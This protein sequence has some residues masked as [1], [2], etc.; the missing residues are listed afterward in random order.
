MG[1]DSRESLI[2]YAKKHD[3]P[4]SGHQKTPW[5]SDRNLLHISFEGG[6]LEN[7]WAERRKRCTCCPSS[8]EQ[9][10]DQPE[11]IEIEFCQGN[12]VA[13][14]GE[15][16]SPAQLLAQTQRWAASTASAGPTSWKTVMSA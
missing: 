13:I 10:P 2:A 15:A 7:P 11:Y 1:S 14:N 16:L 6:I 8:P 5:S 9:A 12:P 3:I 4:C